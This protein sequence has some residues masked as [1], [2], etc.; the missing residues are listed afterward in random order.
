MR[1]TVSVI[2][3][4]YNQARFLPDAIESALGQT[5]PAVQVIVVDDGSTDA[6]AE[7]CRQYADRILTL[8]QENAGLS[9]ARNAGIAASDGEFL[10]F[11]DADDRIRP[12]KLMEQLQAFEAHPAVGV[13]YSEGVYID[14]EGRVTGPVPVNH[15]SGR[16]FHELLTLWGT[17][18][19][20]PL[21]R[22]ECLDRVGGFDPGL[23]S[24][25]DYDLWLRIAL[26]YPFLALDRVHFE[27]R[28]WGNTM[29]RN[30]PVMLHSAR[31]ILRRYGYVHPGC[32]ECARARRAGLRRWK[33]LVSFMMMQQARQYLAQGDRVRAWQNVLFV[34]RNN[35]GHIRHLL[36]PDALAGKWRALWRAQRSG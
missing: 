6:T 1:P 29:S 31:E 26:H 25:E 13:V 33:S 22:R 23:R 18:A 36:R 10:Q 19:H 12:D 30:G 2:I 27:Y 5:W 21:V 35:P 28:V 14:A 9:A 20:A 8:R 17:V 16:V 24:F 11:L 32:R 3:P 4:C 34:L 7:V 15:P